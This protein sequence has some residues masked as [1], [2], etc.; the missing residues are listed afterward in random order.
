[1]LLCDS[2]LVA[3]GKLFIL[4]GGWSV[5]GPQPTPMAIALKLDVA[6]TELED[7]HHWEMFLE[8]AD[9]K[10]IIFDT[11]EGPRPVEVRGDFQV[12][13]PQG[14]IEGARVSVNLAIN[15]GPLPFTPGQR[16]NWKLVIDGQAKEEWVLSFSTRSLEEPGFGQIPGVQQS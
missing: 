5:I 10:E 3:E 1:M 15:I 8:D 7:A 9:G 13:R 2:A 6:W 14:A 11:P 4:G 16:F 12:G